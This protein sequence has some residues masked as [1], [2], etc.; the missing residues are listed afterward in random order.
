MTARSGSKRR[1]EDTA[2][3]D[4]LC[5][6]AIQGVHE[7][8]Y[9]EFLR[10]APQEKPGEEI[11][12]SLH[13]GCDRMRLPAHIEARAGFYLADALTAV[14]PSTWPDAFMDARNVMAGAL[15]VAAG[16]RQVV[17]RCAGGG[18]HAYAGRAA[19]GCHL[20]HA[21]IAASFLRESLPRVA[22]LSLG[23]HHANGTQ[24]IFMPRADVLTVSVHGDPAQRYPFYTGY[25]DEHGSEDAAGANLNLVLGA[26]ADEK[27]ADAA[28]AEACEAIRRFS[29]GAVVVDIE[30]GLS[31]PF[32]R[33]AMSGPAAAAR[34]L[35]GAL[36]CPV[37]VI[38]CETS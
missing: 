6:Y 28:L 25:A 27:T 14:S 12:A 30:A 18:R 29:P 9:L 4:S 2:E 3:L 33:L 19:H 17:I 20:N 31:A 38:A 11:R 32:D 21:A 22:V 5:Q 15:R 13:P 10:F 34:K 23:E 37:M 1:D 36:N 16:E 26:E 8:S 7:A 24:S 35:S